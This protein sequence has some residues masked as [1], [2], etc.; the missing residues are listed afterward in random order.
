MAC[1]LSPQP[2]VG[3]SGAFPLL[4]P[5][6]VRTFAQTS[7]AS[8]LPQ[9]SSLEP[10]STNT[11]PRRTEHRCERVE[12][13]QGMGEQSRAEQGRAKQGS[14]EQGIS[15]SSRAEQSR[16]EQSRAQHSTAQKTERRKVRRVSTKEAQKSCRSSMTTRNHRSSSVT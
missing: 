1:L 7:A 9:C 8:A 10:I 13:E 11:A 14:A 12:A 5:H 3:P 15:K 16:A 6:L 2:L 4:R